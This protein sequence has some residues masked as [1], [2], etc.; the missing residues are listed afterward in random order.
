MP[1][2]S[3][4]LWAS[5][6]RAGCTPHLWGSGLTSLG[7]GLPRQAEAFVWADN[8]CFQQLFKNGL[9]ILSLLKC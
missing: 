4:L 8:C 6:V 7:W 3:P 9:K 1:L 2:P 5:K